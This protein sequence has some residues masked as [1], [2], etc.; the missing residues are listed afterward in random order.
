MKRAAALATALA[1]LAGCSRG[2]GPESAE[3]DIAP[4][5]ITTETSPQ[6]PID[7]IGVWQADNSD[8]VLQLPG[9]RPMLTPAGRKLA[10]ARRVAAAHSDRSWDGTLR[11]MPPGVPRILG[12][13]QP[14]DINADA[15]LIV[16]GFQYQRLVR[17]IYM[18]DAY[19]IDPGPT[20]MGES[21]GRW[22][23]DTLVVETGNFVPGLALDGS[24]LPQSAATMLTERYE[25]IDEDTLIDYI[26]V[27]DPEMYQK[28]WQAQVT[29]RRIAG[30]TV[31]EDVCTDRIARATAAAADVP[32]TAPSP[33]PL[34]GPPTAPQAPS[35]P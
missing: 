24:G 12:F 3:P 18:D 13:G 32:A 27:N 33:S 35:P 7:L 22:E 6:P 2:N 20:W 28:P 17:M 23:G 5:E 25:H 29:L 16:M 4:P 21:H 26:T 9:E 14:F 31:R 10:D 34:P 19:P 11:C 30:L 8:D 15:H 1:L